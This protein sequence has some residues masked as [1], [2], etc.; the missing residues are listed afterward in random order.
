MRRTF[1]RRTTTG[2]QLRQPVVD[3]VDP[4]LDLDSYVAS[5]L[6]DEGRV[7]PVVWSMTDPGV[8]GFVDNGAIPQELLTPKE[9]TIRGVRFR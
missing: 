9:E 1:V 8:S 5:A 2:V 3:G 4:N 7:E 6:D